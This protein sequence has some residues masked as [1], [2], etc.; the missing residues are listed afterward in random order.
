MTA[1]GELLTVGY[2]Q[3]SRA[4]RPV[5]RWA[6]GQPRDS[7]RLLLARRRLAR[8]A[9]SGPATLL[10]AGAGRPIHGRGV[11]GRERLI[12]A[13]GSVIRKVPGRSWISSGAVLDQWPDG[14]AACRAGVTTYWR[15]HRSVNVTG[16]RGPGR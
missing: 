1:H 4:R 6:C 14:A 11:S 8:A 5:R 16:P 7:P 12:R 10:L 2:A 13:W 15:R 3:L 9:G